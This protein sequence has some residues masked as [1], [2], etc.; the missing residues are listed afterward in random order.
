MNYRY[1]LSGPDTIAPVRV[2][3]DGRRTYFHF[4]QPGFR[5]QIFAMGADG[6]EMPVTGQAQAEMIVVDT[7]A[8]RFVV[9]AGAEMVTVYNEGARL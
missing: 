6:R 1:T 5:P 2:Y 3:D 7:V 9:R 8:S 4:A